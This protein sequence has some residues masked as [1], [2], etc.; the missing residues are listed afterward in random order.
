MKSFQEPMVSGFKI[1][2]VND[3]HKLEQFLQ[4]S[5]DAQDNSQHETFFCRVLDLL[6]SLWC[7]QALKERQLE[8]LLIALKKKQ[9]AEVYY[10][11]VLLN[12]FR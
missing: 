4:T 11:C 8:L 10:I 1:L 2:S 12:L 9:I 6:Y 5:F 7:S 3:C